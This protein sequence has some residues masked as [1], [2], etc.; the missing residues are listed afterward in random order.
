[1]EEKVKKKK[2][3]RISLTAV[4][5]LIQELTELKTEQTFLST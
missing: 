1:M 4:E 3:V 2:L 5:A